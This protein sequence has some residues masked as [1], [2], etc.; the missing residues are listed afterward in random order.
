MIS[1]F[2][3]KIH[4]Q[5][6]VRIGKKRKIKVIY[7]LFSFYWLLFLSFQNYINLDAF[8]HKLH[9]NFED[10]WEVSKLLYQTSNWWRLLLLLVVVS[11]CLFVDRL[12]LKYWQTSHRV[13]WASDTGISMKVLKPK[14]SGIVKISSWA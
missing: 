12:G 9:S 3:I 8:E 7:S 14:L 1:I 11:C 10:V 4:L 5:K 6:D 2:C 13:V